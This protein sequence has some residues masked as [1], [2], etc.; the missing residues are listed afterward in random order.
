MSYPLSSNVSSGQPTEAAHYNNLRADA[1]LLGQAEADSVKL[2]AFLS[3]YVRGV[4]LQYLATNRLRIPFITS[5]P[6]TLMI[7]GC[8]CQAA[9][10]V[11]LPSGL[12]SGSAATWYVF[13]QRTAGQT[14]FTLTVNTS[15][16]EGTNQRV[17]GEFDWD[18]SDIISIRDYFRSPLAD[19]DYDSGWFAVTTGVTYTKA[20]GLPQQPLLVLI[21]H[22]TLA[23]GSDEW[24]WVGGVVT[25]TTFYPPY[26]VD[27]TN[28]YV[29]TGTNAGAGVLH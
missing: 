29:Q 15:A 17:I 25:S 27:R 12:I 1:L 24:V 5:D 3:R 11:D 22:S 16:T 13:A 10:N 20:H 23:N 7:S 19:P 18:G 21:Y 26:G 2:N 4:K 28:I 6:P 14:T 8:M 9:T